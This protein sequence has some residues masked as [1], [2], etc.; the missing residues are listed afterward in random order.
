[1]TTR[2]RTNG[3]VRRLSRLTGACVLLAGGVGAS[4][5][6]TAGTAEASG[7]S[8][9]SPTAGSCTINGSLDLSAGSLSLEAPA[10]LSWSSAI[11]GYNLNLVDTTAGDN[12]FTIIDPTG[13]NDG[14]NVT[15]AATTF[16]N[17]SPSLSLANAGT[18]EID[19]STSSETSGL[20]ANAC[21]A[22]STCTAPATG[23][24]GGPGS[25]NSVVTYPVDITTATSSPTA[26]VIYNADASTGEGANLIDPVG[27]WLNV[28]GNTQAG[29]A[30]A[31]V[32]TLVISSGPATV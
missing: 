9:S 10:T 16:H 23:A 20:P 11:T 17:T 6:F 18:F 31:S 3:T 22:S 8:P 5:L 2:Q 13:S 7:C 30:Y 26:Y 1:M 15:A 25:T 29:S 28:P 32:I 12:E 24:T 21:A 4:A 14:W 27:W 19:G